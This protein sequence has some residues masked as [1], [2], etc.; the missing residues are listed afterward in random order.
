MN[1]LELVILSISEQYGAAIKM[2]EISITQCRDELWQDT[3]GD[4]IIS[5]I[6]YHV[7]YWIDYYLS[8]NKDEAQ[9]FKSFKENKHQKNEKF[10]YTKQ[11]LLDYS[12]FVREKADNWFKEMTMDELTTDSVFDFHGSTL[13][14][15]LIYDLRHI[16]LHVGALHV[17]LNKVNKEPM[18]WESHNI[19]FKTE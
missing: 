8:R 6:I 2:L 1:T 19:L 14:S 4:K 18:D 12:N 9:I 7:L 15:S 10:V 5:H 16:M 13:L 17:R 11:E 3:T